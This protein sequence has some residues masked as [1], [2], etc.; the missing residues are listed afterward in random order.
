[1]SS[2]QF[3]QRQLKQTD[4]DSFRDRHKFIISS[5]SWW[6]LPPILF[7]PILLYIYMCG[8]NIATLYFQL[9]SFMTV[10]FTQ[11][12]LHI[13]SHRHT[14]C[15]GAFLLLFISRL[16]RYWNDEVI[17]LPNMQIFVMQC[18]HCLSVESLCKY[19]TFSDKGTQSRP[20]ILQNQHIYSHL[21]ILNNS[22]SSLFLLY[23]EKTSSIST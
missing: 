5:I 15:L 7:F 17:R 8:T 2:L 12:R 22:L 14:H 6:H 23:E 18:V 1:M 3:I 9:H 20:N 19:V 16:H 13:Y 4:D 10:Y 11:H 21:C